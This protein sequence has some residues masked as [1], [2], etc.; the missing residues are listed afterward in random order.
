MIF[1]LLGCSSDRARGSAEENSVAT[2]HEVGVNDLNRLFVR[3]MGFEIFGLNAVVAT[4]TRNLKPGI[5]RVQACDRILVFLRTAP[6]VATLRKQASVTST[7]GV[8]SWRF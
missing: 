4:G 7:C 3:P 1:R 5:D 2:E 6:R 8:L